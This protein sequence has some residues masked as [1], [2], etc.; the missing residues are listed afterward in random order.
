MPLQALRPPGARAEPE[1]LGACVRCGL[2]VRG[3]PF[4]TLKLAAFGEEVPQI[5]R[6]PT[7]VDRSKL[8]INHPGYD[9]KYAKEDINANLPFDRLNELVANGTIGSL[10][11]QTLVLMGLQ[12][13]VGPLL[14]ETVPE[15]VETF[16]AD[17]V[18]A[19][20]L[21]PS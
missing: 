3:C 2:C 1:F 18:E 4:D 21:V 12:P 19:A 16:K 8:R 10:S 20:L 15:I 13:N 17:G 14:K 9:H 6:I 7:D 11:E 5:R